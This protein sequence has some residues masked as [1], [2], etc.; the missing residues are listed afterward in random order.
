[1]S[2]IPGVTKPLTPKIEEIPDGPFQNSRIE[3]PRA[4]VGI[5]KGISARLSRIVVQRPCLLTINHASGT[6]A[7][8]SSEDTARPMMKDHTTANLIP[9]IT[10]ALNVKFGRVTNRKTIPA[11]A[12]A[13]MMKRK[14]TMAREYMPFVMSALAES[15]SSL[16]ANL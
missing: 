8:T 2:K 9:E 4:T 14:N 7:K 12:G 16:I 1:M 3:K 15:L 11:I 5:T 13:T 10:E 6:P